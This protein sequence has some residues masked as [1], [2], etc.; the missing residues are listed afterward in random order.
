[1][2]RNLVRE[3][4]K[5]TSVKEKGLRVT[6]SRIKKRHDLKS[7]EQAA[8]YYIKNKRL[9]I[10]ISSLID[11]VTRKLFQELIT[12]PP[13]RSSFAKDTPGKRHFSEFIYQNIGCNL[14]GEW[15]RKCS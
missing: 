1:M 2:N 11:D 6:L 15:G 9:D 8:C 5:K 12:A 10:N 14:L 13:R 4:V 3:I 7:I